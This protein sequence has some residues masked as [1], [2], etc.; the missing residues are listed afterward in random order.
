MV[1]LIRGVMGTIYQETSLYKDF[2][3]TGKAIG[4]NRCF[5]AEKPARHGFEGCGKAVHVGVV[6]T[7]SESCS[8]WPWELFSR[9][10]V[11]KFANY[12]K[13]RNF[14][15][16][17]F[18]TDNSRSPLSCPPHSGPPWWPCELLQAV[19]QDVATGRAGSN[20]SAPAAPYLQ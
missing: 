9:F 20:S 16:E 19:A 12:C 4:W 7:G 15:W 8:P 3:T 6:L 11:E 18:I 17:L 10:S 5:R 2:L 14:P 1:G 13:Q